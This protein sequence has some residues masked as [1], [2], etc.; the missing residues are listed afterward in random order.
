MKKNVFRIAFIA[1][2]LVMSLLPSLG[3]LFTG[4]SEALANEARAPRPVLTDDEGKLNRF[5]LDEFG[6]FFAGRIAFR[7]ELV[8]AWASLN[9]RL[10]HSSTEKK[11]VL[12]A[13]DWLYFEP[14]MDDYMGRSMTDEELERTA[15]NLARMQACCEER[16]ARFIFTIAPNKNSLYPEQM[17]AW[18]VSGH[19]SSNAVKLRPY[20]EKYGVH[21]VDLFPVF[22]ENGELLYYR[23]DSHWTDRGAALAAD[24]LL[25]ALDRSSD[26]Y[27]GP[28][29]P[30]EGHLG[31]L[32]NMIYPAGTLRET[33]EEY[34]PG[35][36][37]TALRNPNG[38]ETKNFSTSCEAGEGTLLCWRDSFGNSLYPYLA[39]SFENARFLNTGSYDLSLVERLG[40]QYVIFELV[41]RN[42]PTICGEEPPIQFTDGV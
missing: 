25:G 6:Q 31:D 23:T 29:A 9:S 19:D 30:G 10:L 42:L 3:M 14:T 7:K 20:L 15:R 34:A 40:A 22:E 8:T 27:T 2:F 4:P 5:V 36:H 35:F 41:E 12:G 37:F 24:A 16:G 39:E 32:Y 28:Y 18:I 33:R 38:G 26:Y 1:L 17:P 21:Y 11:V 13:D